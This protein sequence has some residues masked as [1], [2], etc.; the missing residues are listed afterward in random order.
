[1]TAKICR[2]CENPARTRG[3]CP[4][5]YAQER[6]GTQEA[7][8]YGDKTPVK[9]GV[10]HCDRESR[11]FSEGSLC[12]AHYQLHYRG[13]DPE[14]RILR[15]GDDVRTDLKCWVSTCPKRAA[16][17]GLC[18]YHYGRARMGKIEVPESLGVALNPPCSYGTCNR[19]SETKG[20]C[21]GHYE[22]LRSGRGLT[23][24]REWGKYVK[25]DHVCSVPECR[26][27][28]VTTKLCPSHAAQ[29]AKYGL[30]LKEMIDVWTDPKC[31]NPGCGSTDNLCMDHNHVTGAYRGLL[32]NGCNTALG[33]LNESPSRLAGLENYIKRF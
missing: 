20:L 16:T 8:A 33:F 12:Q 7:S 18:G 31:E 21:H 24:L 17:K 28:S 26:K 2:K 29:R 10:T 30:T 1:M 9:C 14:T 13:V 11:G 23:E 5:H 4:K 25:G 3:L 32:C 22:Q 27:A 6:Y 15:D 19:V